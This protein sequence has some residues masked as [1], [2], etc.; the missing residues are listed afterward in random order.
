MQRHHV[1]RQR[2][3]VGTFH[4]SDTLILPQLPIQLAITHIDGVHMRRAVAQQHVGKAAGGSADIHSNHACH[5]RAEHRNRTLNLV[6]APAGQGVHF[7]AQ[8]QLLIVLHGFRSLEHLL[9]ADVNL[10]S[11]NQRLRLFAAGRNAAAYQRAVYPRFHALL[12]LLHC[13]MR[14]ATL[15][16]SSPCAR[17][18]NV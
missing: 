14:R 4:Y 10:P 3:G 2:A 8:D 1:G 7:T 5:I 11:H 12:S 17:S 16:A 18:C 13:A 9:F 15:S 6:P